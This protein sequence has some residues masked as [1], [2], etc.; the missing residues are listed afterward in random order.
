MNAC[1]AQTSLYPLI[2]QEYLRCYGGILGKG[3]GV[4]EKE[5]LRSPWCSFA[6]GL[7]VLEKG[8]GGHVTM[9]MTYRGHTGQGNDV[10]L[11]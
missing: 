5:L 4:E 8:F 11:V 10:S 2:I 3:K 9:T 7:L 6:I 1:L